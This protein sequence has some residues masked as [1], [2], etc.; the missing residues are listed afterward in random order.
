M[1][2]QNLTAEIEIK[3]NSPLAK[4]QLQQVEKQLASLNKALMQAGDISESFNKSMGDLDV[5]SVE[6]GVEGISRS[7]MDLKKSLPTKEFKAF[8]KS[9]MADNVKELDVGLVSLDRSL[10]RLNGDLVTTE[11]ELKATDFTHLLKQTDKAKDAFKDLDAILGDDSGLLVRKK[12]L[13]SLRP[14][15]SILIDNIEKLS[16]KREL[17]FDATATIL[18]LEEINKKL[19]TAEEATKQLDNTNKEAEEST[20]A[21]SDTIGILATSTATLLSL[22]SL[23]ATVFKETQIAQTINSLRALNNTLGS[24]TEGFIKTGA[25]LEKGLVRSALFG[26]DTFKKF[27]AGIT[28][29]SGRIKPFSLTFIEL[30]AVLS[31]LLIRLGLSLQFVDNAVVDLTGAF[32]VITGILAG[33]FASAVSFALSVVG[34]LAVG[35]GV[36]LLNALEKFDQVSTK[37]EL[38]TRQFTFTIENFS[39]TLGTTAVGSLQQW[40]DIVASVN[41]T[42]VFTINN[43]QKSIKLLVSEGTTL[44]LTFKDNQKLLEDAVE[45]AS[46]TGKDLEDVTQALLSGLAGQS[47]AAF[48]LGLN[49]RESALSHGKATDAAHKTVKA[50]TEE[51][52]VRKRLSIITERANILQ[53]ASTALTETAIGQSVRLAKAYEEIQTKLGETNIVLRAINEAE[54]TFINL[55]NRIPQPIFDIIALLGQ[56]TGVLLVVVGTIT[57]NVLIISGL[58]TLYKFFNAAVGTNAVLQGALTK[59]VNTAN[60]ALGLQAV[61]ITSLNGLLIAMRNIL[62]AIA[63]TSVT[64]IFTTLGVALKA[65]A[66][67]A[68]KFLIIL[69]PLL[70]KLAAI[71]IAIWLVIRALSEIVEALGESIGAFTKAFKSSDRLAQEMREG[72]KSSGILSEALAD[73]TA[74]AIR[75]ANVLGG[76]AKLIT[77]GITGSVLLLNE[78]ILRLRILMADTEEESMAL[79]AALIEVKLATGK[80]ASAGE[81]AG[82]A[83]ATLGDSSLIA[84]FKAAKYG[85]ALAKANKGQKDLGDQAE[86]TGHKVQRT[87]QQIADSIENIQQAN[88]RLRSDIDATGAG[89]VETIRIRL[90]LEKQILDRKIQQLTAE[91]SLKEAQELRVQQGLLEKKAIAE[92][93]EVR[94]SQAMTILSTNGQIAASIRMAGQ[95]GL[96]LEQ[97]RLNFAIQRLNKEIERVTIEDKGNAETL[98][99]LQKQKS[100]LAQL[101]NKQLFV[102]SK[103][104]LDALFKKEKDLER[105][106]A[107]A[108]SDEETRAKAQ[109]DLEFEKI[110]TALMRLKIENKLS[111]T[112]IAAAEKSAKAQKDLLAQ[113]KSKGKS[114]DSGGGFDILAGL[115]SAAGF[116]GDTVGGIFD[117]AGAASENF[118][119]SLQQS[120]NTLLAGFEKLPDFAMTLVDSGIDMMDQMIARAPEVI[121]GMIDALPEM[122]DKMVAVFMRLTDALPAIVAQIADALPDIISKIFDQIPAIISKIFEAIPQIVASLISA[123]PQVITNIL[124]RLPE[125]ISAFIEGFIGASGEIAGALIDTFITKGGAVKI[126]VAIVKAIIQSI[127]AIVTGISKGIQRALKGIFSGFE[128]PPFAGEKLIKNLQQGMKKVI[129]GLTGA[130]EQAFGVIDIPT[131]GKA[132]KELENAGDGIQKMINLAGKSVAGLWDSFLAALKKL[133]MWV[134]T[135]F[136]KFI[137]QPIKEVWLFVWKLLSPFV[138]ALKKV[139]LFVWKKVLEPAVKLLTS[140]YKA[141]LKTF[142][143]VVKLLGEWGK[144]TWQTFMNA[145]NLLKEWGQTVWQVFQNIINIFKEAFNVIINFFQQIFKG[146]VEEAFQGVFDFF[147]ELPQ[148]V[149]E[150]FKPVFDFFANLKDTLIEAFKPIT[151]FASNIKAKM[152]EAFAPM[153][154]F[155]NGIVGK[156]GEAFRPIT[157]FFNGLRGVFDGA[158]QPIRDFFNGLTGI[159]DG[160]LSGANLSKLFDPGSISGMIQKG[161]DLL[162]PGNL[163][164]KLFNIDSGLPSKGKIEGIIG[165]DLPYANFAQGGVVPG[166]APTKGDSLLN[167]KILAMLSPGEFVVPRSIAMMPGMHDFLAQLVKSGQLP[168]FG[169]GGIVKAVASGD[170]N[171]VKNEVSGAIGSDPVGGILSS[172]EKALEDTAAV[173]KKALSDTVAALES[174][175]IPDPVKYLKQQFGGAIRKMMKANAFAEGGPT[176]AGGPAL[177]HPGEFVLRQSAVEGIGQQQAEFINRNGRLPQQ[178]NMQKTQNVTIVFEPGSIAMQGVQD[179]DRFVDELIDTMKRRGIDGDF[180]MSSSGLRETS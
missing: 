104:A 158:I 121:Q 16:E 93:T 146:N 102:K 70:I 176:G 84:S 178:G 99:A 180:I 164:N 85:D 133:W 69:A 94:K 28:A 47:Q 52:K 24:L 72:A 67:A 74:T 143:N 59:A 73:L 162:N 166:T 44:G 30:S 45:I 134:W 46:A 142:K 31:P 79:K 11:K 87:A 50:L 88:L 169:L 96:T 138:K 98:A 111:E 86:E 29:V 8:N 116:I 76:I 153:T 41:K 68:T 40:E 62:I 25:A 66:V 130:T 114:D 49:L 173:S 144:A 32:L 42:T 53:G 17:N 103:K 90:E 75:V 120:N 149:M 160:A 12:A 117:A 148:K 34:D 108:S 141:V 139:W 129:T 140:W 4:K 159:F 109:L 89:Q 150:A 21:L 77:I 2:D 174:L 106:L 82:V 63:S 15:T 51:Q 135:M 57:A 156:M 10:Q 175:G 81:D 92:I 155:L 83:V 128:I 18:V 7:F 97:T 136:D 80:L 38:T 37:V 147:G 122:I 54:I 5:K 56:L 163:L 22:G 60:A 101:S 23:T 113:M 65:A 115:G 127:G 26:I 179:P 157:D 78:G 126:A 151:D 112:Q 132:Q 110:D 6:S 48:A 55:L 39:K 58:I 124:D 71:G 95:E 131:G 27:G 177:L 172:G 165:L 61:T 107:M 161:L 154:N 123:I 91:K 118:A 9:L 145:V 3:T 105:S 14:D 119:L 33:S 19:K 170:P 137:I 100:L 167:D 36:K 171:A 20:G 13:R 43:I 64:A 125:I 1:A 168:Q 152:A 35:L